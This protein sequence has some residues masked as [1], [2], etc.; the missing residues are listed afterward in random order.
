MSFLSRV[1]FVL[2]VPVVALIAPAFS[3]GS[4]DPPPPAESAALTWRWLH[5][6]GGQARGPNGLGATFLAV[7]RQGSRI[8]AMG[9]VQSIRSENGGATWAELPRTHN[10]W[11]VAF[12]PEGLILLGGRGKVNRSTDGGKTWKE[13]KTPEDG[14]VTAISLDGHQG[15]AVGRSVLR[16]T[17]AGAS[18]RRVKAP[19]VNYHDIAT[20]GRTIVVVGGAGLVM[21]SEDGGETWREHWLPTHALLTSVAF[22]GERVVVI[23]TGD[24]TLLRSTDAGRSWAMIPSPAKARLRGIAFSN[25]EGLAV[26]YWG[27]VIRT[28]DR[29]ATWRR[30]RSGTRLHLVG[31]DADSSG[32]F[33]VSG[34]RE[35]VL[36]ATTGDGK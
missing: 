1:P 6:H 24:G 36:S 20:R 11:G 23:T 12:G 29:G 19:M 27:E 7:G 21:R 14:F 10:G 4:L 5:Q 16:S 26:G 3:R 22:A 18:W 25:G 2:L 33:V 31:V 17:D 28:T 30:E 35:A 34:I 15:I 8:Y 32:G 13:I 9:P